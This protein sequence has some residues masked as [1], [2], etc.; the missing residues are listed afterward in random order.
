M[1]SVFTSL[2]IVIVTHFDWWDSLEGSHLRCCLLGSKHDR[3]SRFFSI[4][5]CCVWRQPGGQFI[6]SSVRR[7]FLEVLAGSVSHRP[8]GRPASQAALRFALFL[9][10]STACRLWPHVY[11]DNRVGL[12]HCSSSTDSLVVCYHQ[13]HNSRFAGSHKVRASTQLGKW[14]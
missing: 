5:H 9:K 7:T 10:F 6:C 4:F 11:L 3:E 8:A 12:G 13:S 2:I 14:I 1:S